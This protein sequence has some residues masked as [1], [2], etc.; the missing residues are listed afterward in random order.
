MNLK[1][2][3]HVST[4]EIHRATKQLGGLK[5]PDEDGFSGIFYHKYWHLVG[6]YVCKAIS[7]FFETGHMLPEINKTLVVLI[8]KVPQPESLSQFYQLVFV[9]LFTESFQRFYQTD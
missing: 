7:Y 1:L 8:P 2:Q 9:I 5:A 4:E 6:N 3:A